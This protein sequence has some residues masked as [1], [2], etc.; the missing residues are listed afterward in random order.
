MANVDGSI[1]SLIQGVSQQPARTRLLGQCTLQENFRSNPVEGLQRR[2]PTEYIGDLFTD[3]FDQQWYDVE[4]KGRRFI[5]GAGVGGIRAYNT[6]GEEY[7]ILEVDDATDYLDGGKLH[8]A[9]IED[10]TYI[11]NTEKVVAMDAA[12]KSYNEDSSIVYILG[13]NYSKPFKVIVNVTDKTS[14]VTTTTTVTHTT[15][16][17]SNAA[18]VAQIATDFIADAIYDLLVAAAP[19]NVSF[20]LFKDHIRIK[21]TSPS[22]KALNVQSSDGAYDSLMKTVNQTVTSATLVPRYA[23]HGMM[24]TVQTGSNADSPLLYLEFRVTPKTDTET[25]T[26]GSHFGRDGIWYESVAPG[27]PYLMDVTTMPHVLTYDDVAEE[28]TFSP[29]EWKGRQVGD[30]DS[31][32]DPSFIGSTINWLAYFQGRLVMLTGISTVMS[33]TNDPLD[34]FFRS[35]VSKVND[36]PIDIRSTAKNVSALLVAIPFNRDLIIFA[37]NNAQFI[38]FGRTALTSENASLVLTTTFESELQAPPVPAG[39]N[40]FFGINYGEFTGIREFFTEGTEDINDARPITDHVLKYMPGKVHKLATTSNFNTLLVQTD[41]S[42]TNMYPYEYIWSGDSKLQSSWS[43]WITPNSLEHFFFVE[44]VIYMVAKIGD[45]YSLE[46][47][48]LD[49]QYDAELNYQVHLDRKVFLTA[50]GDTIT[51]PYEDAPDIDD[52]VFIQGAD[53]PTPGLRATVEDYDAGT[54]LVTFTKD[55][56]GAEI[57]AGQ[58][59]LSRYRPTMPFIKD[60]DGVKIGTARLIISKF[61]LNYRDSGDFYCDIISRFRDT[62]TVYFSGRIADDPS[63]QVGVA[64]IQSGSFVMPFRENADLAE[65]EIY[66]QSE[67]PLTLM[68]IEYLGQYTKKGNR[69][70]QGEK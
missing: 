30:E 29:G 43:T 28:F 35:A 8:F 21:N 18:H 33:R 62:D 1:R 61:L 54:G 24:V 69:I 10:T 53:C 70:T 14:N 3:A 12:T 26:T 6:D 7:D 50:T 45:N 19:S 63:T 38:I 5:I 55:Y 36:D 68:D 4:L 52:M 31:N 17:G 59:Y 65:L 40:I 13:G 16:D 64:P 27:I 25:L 42:D 15:P 23:P 44:S 66:S 41:S 67:L 60:A 48:D 49:Q 58:R 37:S 22:T 47:I 57:I 9:T 20:E 32:S 46:K 34:Y 2:P 11:V 56:D 39:R 51:L